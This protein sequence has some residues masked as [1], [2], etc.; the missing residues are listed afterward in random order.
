MLE[1]NERGRKGQQR[2]EREA[3]VWSLEAGK[4]VSWRLDFVPSPTAR[5]STTCFVLL[6]QFCNNKKTV[7][8][9]REGE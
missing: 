8:G 9:G 4:T 2:A 5:S 6:E 3:W 7:V 1:T